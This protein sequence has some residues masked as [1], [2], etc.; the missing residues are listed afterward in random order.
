MKMA[1]ASK[2]IVI[3]EKK[4]LKHNNYWVFVSFQML[5]KSVDLPLTNRQQR[6]R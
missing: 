2:I 5:V 4:L 1:L 3:A 6:P